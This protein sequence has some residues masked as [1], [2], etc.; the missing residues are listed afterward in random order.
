MRASAS[1]ACRVSVRSGLFGK[2]Q[3]FVILR[4]FDLNQFVQPQ[5]LHLGNIL[6]PIVKAVTSS[7]E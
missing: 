1:T 3:E 5:L 7:L 6:V 2:L 4:L